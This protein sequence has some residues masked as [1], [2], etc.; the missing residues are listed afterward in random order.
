MNHNSKDLDEN[1]RRSL[2]ITSIDINEI[3]DVENELKDVLRD[4]LIS[5]G[6]THK[7]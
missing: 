2:E 4:T 6:K 7:K 1:E 5:L 3:K